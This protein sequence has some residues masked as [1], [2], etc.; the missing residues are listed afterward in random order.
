MAAAS[1]LASAAAA[2][3]ATAA[4]AVGSAVFSLISPWAGKVGRAALGQAGA[5]VAIGLQQVRQDS[6]PSLLTINLHLISVC[7]FS[8]SRFGPSRL[9]LQVESD[10]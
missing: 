1:K 8:S 4:V 5:G 6:H 2:A 10:L 7:A 9:L 3:T